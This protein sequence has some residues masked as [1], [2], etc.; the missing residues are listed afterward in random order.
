MFKQEYQAKHI[1]FDGSGKFQAIGVG[2]KT[3]K[4]GKFGII[5]RRPYPCQRLFRFAALS[6]SLK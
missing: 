2:S 5:S 6:R 3:A 4:L 1:L